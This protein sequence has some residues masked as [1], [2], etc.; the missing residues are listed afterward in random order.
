M[1]TRLTPSEELASLTLMEEALEARPNDPGGHIR[2]ATDASEAVRQRALRLLSVTENSAVSV[3]TG[4]ASDHGRD[5][6]DEPVPRRIGAYQI[7]RVLGRGGMGTVYQAERADADFDHVVAIKVIKP[8]ILSDA[9]IERFRRERRI[10][11]SLRHPHIAHLYDGGE[12]EAGAPYIVMEMID[13]IS[14]KRWLEQ[15]DPSLERRLELMEQVCGAVEFAHHNLVVHRDLTPGNILVTDLDQAKLIDFG[16][17]RPDQEGGVAARQSPLSKLSLTPGF[18]A[19]EII[20]GAPVTTLSDVYSL[21]RIFSTMLAGIEE[22]ELHAIAAQA[23]A[24]DPAARYSSAALMAQDIA[25]FPQGDPIAAYSKARPYHIRK[26]AARYR[27]PLALVTLSVVLLMSGL[28]GVSYWWRQAESEHQA[29]EQR[30]AE[31]RELSKFL[32]FD[33]YDELEDV[34]GNTKALNDIADHARHYLDTLSGTKGASSEVKLE[35]ALAYKRLSDVLGTPIGANLGRRKE[36]GE[37]LSI[38]MSQLR[39]LHA[40]NP[41]DRAITEGLADTLYSQAI[42]AF[43]ALDDNTAAHQAGNQSAVLYR[44]LSEGKD[45]AHET[46][47]A[48]AI[49]AE[50]AA[51]TPLSWIDRGDEA[52]AALK[53][54]LGRM[55]HYVARYGRSAKNLALLARTESALAEALGRLADTG[56]ATYAEGL[57]YADRAI[58]T[59]DAY[60]AAAE[61]KDAARRSLAISLFKRSLTLYS[62]E[63]YEPALADIVRAEQIIAGQIARDSEDTGT[64]RILTSILEQKA[65][66]LAYAGQAREALRIAGRSLEQK[67]AAAQREQD[68]AGRQREYASNLLLVGEVAE[69][70][71]DNAR[72]CSLYREG[73]AVFRKL[74]KRPGLSEFDKE[75]IMN[76]LPE[77]LARTC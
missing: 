45:G 74:G 52:V 27:L 15:A 10:L 56:E 13:G 1:S 6:L 25:R 19:P 66:T 42:F 9:M 77:S 43:I 68:N 38:A 18:A 75:V 76:D 69:I 33:L 64:L 39:A 28:V 11:A 35:A 31:V 24:E 70:G 63:R 57:E 8:G 40:A 59:Y 46:F 32:L 5:L 53:T 4:G 50:I 54:T 67:R 26:F 65:I 41:Q 14:L 62:L 20:E 47:T 58:A 16:I 73:E 23:S 51:A 17:A 12:T 44:Q 48:R 61:K 3:R 30:F 37:A 34:P 60:V 71:G 29:A 22:P 36:A 2:A 21:G 49:D 7:M 55:E 72:A